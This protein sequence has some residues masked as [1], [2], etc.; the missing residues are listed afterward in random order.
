MAR[1]KSRE[2]KI[3]PA[4]KTM[5]FEVKAP[6]P[7]GTSINYIDLSQC[8]SLVNRR[9]YRQG[10]NW[11]VGG[12]TIHTAPNTSGT[13]TIM[14]AQDTWIV[15]NAWHKSFAMWNRMNDQVLDALPSIKSKYHD[16]KVA[17]DSDH[18]S[19]GSPVFT[20]NLLPYTEDSAGNR[21]EYNYGRS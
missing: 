10:L 13:V 16:F 2:T 21:T 5:F 1:R 4:T 8:A 12:F 17:L 9:F 6:G 19:A 18:I 15:S 14:K 7:E 3:Q 20:N 11:A